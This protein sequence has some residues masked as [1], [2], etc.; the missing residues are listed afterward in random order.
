LLQENKKL[1]VVSN[2]L[3]ERILLGTWHPKENTFALA[4]SSS[5]LLYTEKRNSSS[6][7]RVSLDKST[8]KT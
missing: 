6:A 1:Q 5:L 4:K 3:T 7:Y 8:S 2:D